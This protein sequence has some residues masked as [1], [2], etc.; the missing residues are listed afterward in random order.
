MAATSR[1]F[2]AVLLNTL[3]ANVTTSF[4]W[5]AL[6]FWLYVETRSVLATSIVGGSYMLLL[7]V[8]GVPFGSWIDHTRKHRVMVV[9]GV[10]TA[11][12]YAAALGLFLVLPTGAVLTIGS[13]AFI[14]FVTLVLFGAIVESVRGLALSTVVT[15]LVPEPTRANAN[16]QVGMVNGLG[17]AITSVFSGLAVGQLGM[18]WTLVI[19]VALTAVSLAHLLTISI[20]EDVITHSDDL[21]KKVD[22]A[23]AWRAIRA[24]D[25]LLALILFTTLNNLLGGVYMALLDPYGLTL[26]SVEVWGVLWGVLSMG[27]IV[28]GGAVAKWGLGSRPLRSLLLAN[29]AMWVIGL[30]FTLRESIWPLAIGIFCYMVLIPVA[31]ASEQTVLQRVV[32]FEKQGRVFGFAQSVEVAAAPVTAFVVGP[33]AEFW[34]IP[35]SASDAGRR[36]LEPWLGQGNARGMAL[37]FVLTGVIGLLLT[38]AAFVSRPYH[39]L[40]ATHAAAAVAPAAPAA[41]T[42]A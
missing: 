24:I 15:L 8:L 38:L 36:T 28:G 16:G 42:G 19:A 41:A 35:Y 12:C 37:V 30:T 11:V 3:L 33:V 17:F 25:G 2:R 22:F 27:F 32:P 14:G 6:V 1:T 4:L 18:R 40:S 5:F 10:V 21:P 23:G 20:P 31:E 34:L 29:I 7:A 9:A 39:R 26:V 13:P